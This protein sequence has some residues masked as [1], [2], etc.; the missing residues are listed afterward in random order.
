MNSS[1]APSRDNSRHKQN[2]TENRLERSGRPTTATVLP[3]QPYACGLPTH[4]PHVRN[5]NPVHIGVLIWGETTRETEACFWKADRSQF[6]FKEKRAIPPKT[7]RPVPPLY[8]PHAHIAS[9]WTLFPSRT[10][11]PSLPI[12]EPQLRRGMIPVATA[13][14]GYHRCRYGWHQRGRVSRVPPRRCTSS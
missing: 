4:W 3:F 13:R 14:G 9:V 11:R 8:G 2:R 10:T 5:K 7:R 6:H 1:I 12:T